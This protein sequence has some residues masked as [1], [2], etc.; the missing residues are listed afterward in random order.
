MRLDVVRKLSL[1][2]ALATEEARQQMPNRRDHPHCLI[3]TGTEGDEA[4]FA[5]HCANSAGICVPCLAPMVA[6]GAKP[7]KSRVLANGMQP[8][9]PPH[10]QLAMKAGIGY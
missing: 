5:F 10:L 6:T 2:Y 9:R 4:H 3:C 8:P 1:H 7:T